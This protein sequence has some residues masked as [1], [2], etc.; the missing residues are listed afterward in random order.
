MLNPIEARLKRPRTIATWLIYASILLG[1]ALLAQLYS[2]VPSWLFY[3]VLVGWIAYLVVG[4]AV[5]LQVSIAYP[6]SIL[7]AILTLA[8][9]FPQPEHYSFGLSLVTL[10]FTA[11]SIL[12]VGVI[13]AVGRYLILKRRSP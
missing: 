5:T 6:I 2:V 11:G 3:S 12:Q 7:L 10:T 13:L 9:S 4:I 1:V 8:V